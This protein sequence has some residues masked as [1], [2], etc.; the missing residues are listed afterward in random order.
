M[1][2]LLKDDCWLPRCL[3]IESRSCEWKG[4]RSAEGERA[5]LISMAWRPP[6]SR[7]TKILGTRH[8]W[9]AWWVGRADGDKPK[10]SRCHTQVGHFPSRNAL[11]SRRVNMLCYIKY[12]S[13]HLRIDDGSWA[14]FRGR[15]PKGSPFTSDCP[16]IRSVAGRP[17]DGEDVAL[18]VSRAL[19]AWRPEGAYLIRMFARE[20]AITPN[21]SG[22][23][24]GLV[25][26]RTQRPERG[27]RLALVADE[28]AAC[29]SRPGRCA[30]WSA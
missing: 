24:S 21:A 6:R 15:Q 1:W 23:K 4:R 10:W 30:R 9:A 25:D 12:P 29:L 3:I 26:S 2:Q 7:K 16:A 22:E 28:A 11:H 17:S 8:F 14:A 18:S 20:R 19:P 5:T 13:D 27:R